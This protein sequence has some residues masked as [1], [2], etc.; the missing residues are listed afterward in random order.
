MGALFNKELNEE[1]SWLLVFKRIDNYWY[2][3]D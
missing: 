1:S 2:S 3:K